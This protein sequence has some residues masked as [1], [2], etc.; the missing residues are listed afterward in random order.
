MTAA[1]LGIPNKH[2]C[3]AAKLGKLN[4][5]TNNNLRQLNRTKIFFTAKGPLIL[6]Q[7]SIFP[8][9]RDSTFGELHESAKVR[10][11]HSQLSFAYR[12][13]LIYLYLI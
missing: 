4:T 12:V 10:D 9:L 13:S 8:A 5:G 3:I 2:I 6:S 1:E 11:G 7:R